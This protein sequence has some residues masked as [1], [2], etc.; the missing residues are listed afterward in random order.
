MSASP[1][2]V[3]GRGAGTRGWQVTAWW[4]GQ[5]LGDVVREGGR[6]E[7]LLDVGVDVGV[8]GCMLRSCDAD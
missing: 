8:W 4:G 3:A 7:G 2:R 1:S 6:R 5:G